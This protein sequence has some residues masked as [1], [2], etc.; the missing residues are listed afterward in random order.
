[1]VKGSAEKKQ[2]R[3]AKAFFKVQYTMA[4]KI[5]DGDACAF[6]QEIIKRDEEDWILESNGEVGEIWS[7]TLQASVLAHVDCIPEGT[8][9]G[10]NDEWSMA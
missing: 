7:Q 2:N 10:T 9:D 4:K 6:C 8:I 1:M 3:K 5:M